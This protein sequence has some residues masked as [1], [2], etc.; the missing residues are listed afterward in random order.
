MFQ[1]LYKIK[2]QYFSGFLAHVSV[3]TAC[4]LDVAFVIALSNSVEER[5]NTNRRFVT[6]FMVN[7][8]HSI[9]VAEKLTHIGA[10]STGV[11]LKTYLH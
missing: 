4:V 10:V 11:H 3:V 1:L 8:I 9:D 2:Y 5:A 6:D 7:V